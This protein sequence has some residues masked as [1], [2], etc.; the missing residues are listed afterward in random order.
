MGMGRKT[1]GFSLI[2][3]VVAMS[4]LAVIVTAL[5]A[6]ASGS[7]NQLRI[8]QQMEQL[9]DQGAEMAQEGMGEPTGRELRI[10]FREEGEESGTE[11][12]PESREN[13]PEEVLQEYE[14]RAEKENRAFVVWYYQ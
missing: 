3:T 11:Q 13:W 7:R 4:L 5:L 2:E 8:L 12:E 14:V 9:N 1:E 6:A 10:R